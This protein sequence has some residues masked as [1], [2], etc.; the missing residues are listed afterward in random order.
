MTGQETTR[1]PALFLGHGSPMNALLANAFTGFL[2]RLGPALPAPRVVLVVSAHWQTRGT[3]VLKSERPRTIHDFYGFPPELCQIQYPAPG[4]P[5]TAAQVEALMA[6]HAVEADD[7]WGLDH[8]AWALLRHIYPQAQIPVLQLSLN[9]NL[10]MKEHLAL[11]A[12]LKPLREQGVLIVGS[13]NITHNLR[14]VDFKPGAQPRD[15]ALEFDAMIA[16]A[17][18]ARDLP[19]LLALEQGQHSLC[20]QAHPTLEH[21][22]PLLY[23]LGVSDERE[24]L[25]FPYAA[26]EGASLSMRAVRFG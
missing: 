9:Q 23:A 5:S 7:S 17:L 13:G 21:Y 19:R 22:L 12:D 4:S 18:E 2:A 25:S 16:T 15:W 1:M 14:D 11:A 20:A 3:K 26:I 24:A 6:A 10:T 8:G